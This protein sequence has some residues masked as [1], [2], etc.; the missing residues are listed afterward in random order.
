MKAATVS[1]LSGQAYV[2]RDGQ[3]VALES[4]A[5]LSQ[6]DVVRTEAVA[7]IELRFMDD[8]IIELGPDTKIEISDFVFDPSGETEPAFALHM[9][10]GVV[11]SISGKI[12]EQNP[13]SFKLTSPLGAVGI[14][15]TE[16]LHVIGQESEIH[17]IINMEAGHTV[18]ISTSAG[19]SIVLTQSLQ[20]VSIA[21]GGSEM[22]ERDVTPDWVNEF[23]Q[24]V[25]GQ[26]I[27]SG[28]EAPRG[29]YVIADA[30]FLSG[31]DV[32]TNEEGI[33]FVSEDQ[34]DVLA[35]ALEDLGVESEVL[36]EILAELTGT[37]A[38]SSSASEPLTVAQAPVYN[39]GQTNTEPGETKPPVTEPPVDPEPE[40]PKL[41]ED[42]TIREGEATPNAD[43]IIYG[44]GEFSINGLDGNDSI[45]IYGQLDW[46]SSVYGEQSIINGGTA[47]NDSIKIL[48]H[49]VLGSGDIKSGSIY[50]DAHDMNNSAIGGN[51]T[52]Y[53]QGNVGNGQIYG[54]AN[55]MNSS[56]IGGN[57][58]I[59]VGGSLQAGG[60][61]Y[62]DAA[63]IQGNSTGGND[64]INVGSLNGGKIYGDA[65]LM[66]SGTLGNDTIIVGNMSGGAIYGDAD[67]IQGGS[68]AGHDSINVGNMNGGSIY[69]D[70]S[71]MN[72]GTLGNDT[73]VVGNMGGSSAIYGD[74]DTI[75]GGSVAGNDSINVGS[76]GGDGAIYGDAN[77]LSS[78]TPGND[79][80]VVDSMSDN[81]IIYGDANIFQGGGTTGN[82]SINVG[83]LSGNAIIYGDVR[84][85]GSGTMGH[86]TIV[87]GNMSGGTIY[88][89]SYSSD[90]ITAGNNTI[91]VTGTMS[92]GS[93]YA[94]N[95]GQTGSGENSLYVGNFAGGEIYMAGNS[96]LVLDSL[97]NADYSKN[98]HFSS[99]SETIGIGRLADN[100]VTLNL[101][102]AGTNDLLYFTNEYSD[103][104]SSYNAGDTIAAMQNGGN[105]EITLSYGDNTLTL[106]FN[107]AVS[108]TV[109]T[110]SVGGSSYNSFTVS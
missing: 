29:Y 94:S 54:D 48:D 32:P 10:N 105:Y 18:V 99:G 46:G 24:Q 106:L 70:A 19:R 81:A 92:G 61:I 20:G 3:L 45:T 43:N 9:V 49:S 36:E 4:G 85:A 30:A 55:V 103:F 44:G 62:G 86:D 68:I 28:G 7:K 60:A 64:Y 2:E 8:S 39:P 26:E 53:V 69:G 67:T 52:I 50:G 84:S 5:E 27:S 90:S 58:S 15:G 93:I 77:L 71:K 23:L 89:D 73:I 98:I 59:T 12:V 63:T 110:H 34:L 75:Q 100:N 79:T 104:F 80:I 72:S 102:G 38:E 1:S 87:V 95:N 40:E 31:M 22:L 88:G 74:A 37:G 91:N 16:T 42:G 14:R 11:R 82:D 21:A 66:N 97:S 35:T 107:A 25:G 6:S 41:G 101:N 17:S 78:G 13:E 96:S 33:A 57:D 47:G 76:L 108:V 109:G 83:S 65:S 51:D 56:N